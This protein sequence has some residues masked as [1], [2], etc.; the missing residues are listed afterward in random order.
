MSENIY[1]K[2]RL[3]AAKNDSMLKS[4][5]HAYQSVSIPRARLLAIEQ[6]DPQKNMITPNPDDVVSMA[7]AYNAPELC[8]YYCTT[9]CPVG[10]M[11]GDE[12]LLY[13]DLGKISASLMSA[14]H[15]LDAANDEIHRILAD[16]KITQDEKNRFAKI[17]DVLDNITYSASS[18]K[19]W[20]EKNK[21]I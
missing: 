6:T 15:F 19:L 13:D 10:Q 14:L 5:E 12:P 4:V 11:Q 7:K 2:A 9:Q 18:L 3:N 17:V 21:L 16:S 1:K 8:N 20:A